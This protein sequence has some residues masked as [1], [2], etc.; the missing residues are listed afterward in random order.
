MKIKKNELNNCIHLSEGNIKS[1]N[2]D[3]IMFLTWSLPS[4]A[5]C[6]Y[7][8]DMCKKRCFAKK[9]ES[10]KNVRDSRERNLEET[11]LKI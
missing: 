9:N 6:P 3:N 8:T 2:T 1:K 5:T 10:F 11:Q 7:A 4:G